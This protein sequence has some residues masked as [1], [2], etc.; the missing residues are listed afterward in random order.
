MT[1][2]KT[3]TGVSSSMRIVRTAAELREAV[4]RARADGA[5]VGLVPTMGALH[6]GHLALVRRARRDCG[7]VVASLFVN[8]TQFGENEDFSAYPRDETRD[9]E[10]FAANGVDIVYA[11]SA[12]EMYPDGVGITVTVSGVTEGLCGDA[13][14]GHFDGV[15][16]VVSRLFDHCAPDAAYFGEKDYQQLKVVERLAADLG[17]SIRI[18]GIPIVR[19]RDGLALSSR[20]AYL[21]VSERR[22][23]PALHGTLRA[24]AGR[25]AP[26]VDPARQCAWGREALLGAGFDRVDYFEIRDG[27]TLAPAD[28]YR[29]GLRVFVA[30]WLGRTRLIDNIA[31][32]ASDR[33]DC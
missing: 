8:P 1:D 10:L 15:T 14:P 24:V 26:G 22:I 29:P 31:V 17:L 18:V 20:N 6:D 28:A 11:P 3:D 2:V 33:D 16:T 21:N 4:A 7:L 12:E 32:D 9:M 13:R 19:E 23:A 27:G 30:A 25:L 5:I